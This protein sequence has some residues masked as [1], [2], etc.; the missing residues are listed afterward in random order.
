MASGGDVGI[1]VGRGIG[2]ALGSSSPSFIGYAGSG[3]SVGARVTGGRLDRAKGGCGRRRLECGLLWRA[4]DRKLVAERLEHLLG[5]FHAGQERQGVVE[6]VD[7]GLDLAG[8]EL[9]A[10]DGDDVAGG[11]LVRAGLDEN[12]AHGLVDLARHR[13]ELEAGLQRLERLGEEADAPE[14]RGVGERLRDRLANLGVL[15]GRTRLLEL[16]RLFLDLQPR[17]GRRWRRRA[18]PCAAR[19]ERFLRRDEAHR[20]VLLLV[21]R[22]RRH[23]LASPPGD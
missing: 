15:V 9:H 7:G 20:L 17:L 8:L 1:P 11:V 6:A 13:V 19:L 14:G 2:G 21:A 4:V 12:V 22:S 5:L 3:G 10:G 16:D 23:A 18:P